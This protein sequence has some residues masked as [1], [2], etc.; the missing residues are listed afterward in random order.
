MDRILVALTDTMGVER[1]M[2]LLLDDDGQRAARRRPRAA[3]GTTTR[4]SIE[5]PS[6]HPIWKHCWMRR[7]DL[8]RA[9]FD[10]EPDL[11]SREACRDVFDRSRSSCSC[12]S[13][14]ASICSA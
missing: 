2:V 11:E 9:D 14:S 5:I 12:R 8:A 4:S 10:D 6:D 1:A 13:S 3:I 7:E